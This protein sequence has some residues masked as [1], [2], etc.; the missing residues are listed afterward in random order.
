M[1]Y[2]SAAGIR[3]SNA[4]MMRTLRRIKS[5]DERAKLRELV[6]S[7]RQFEDPHFC[8]KGSTQGGTVVSIHVLRQTKRKRTAFVKV[9]L[10]L[11]DGRVRTERNRLVQHRSRWLIDA[12][13]VEVLPNNELQRTRS[14][15]A[16]EPRR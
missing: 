15:Q 13:E 8:W 4:L 9:A 16:M 5:L 2:A 11:S 10:A 3:A 1:L 12:I 14:A 7:L 6:Q